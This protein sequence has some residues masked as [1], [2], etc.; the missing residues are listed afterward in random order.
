[1]VDYKLTCVYRYQLQRYNAGR[2]VYS[3]SQRS[4]LWLHGQ[5]AMIT[6]LATTC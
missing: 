2:L 3:C 6:S 4:Q 5:S 1:M